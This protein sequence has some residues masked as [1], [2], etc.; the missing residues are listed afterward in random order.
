MAFPD[1]M[2]VERLVK[3]LEASGNRTC[4]RHSRRDIAAGDFL[5]SIHRY[6]RTL[7]SL[8]IGTVVL[9][10]RYEAIDTLE[11]IAAD[12]ITDLFLVEPQLFELMDHPDLES[13]D[14]SS[15]RTLTHIGASAPPALRLRARQRFGPRVVHTYGAIE[16]GLVSVLTAAE[17]DPANPEHFHSAGRVFPHVEVRLRRND[18]TI[19]VASETGS[20]EVRSPAMAQGYR[21]RP[22]LEATA[23]RDGWYRSG[24]LRSRKNRSAM[25]IHE[26]LVGVKCK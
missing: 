7:D 10:D 9:R 18:G 15:L 11:T 13:A 19:A 22:D 26:A 23:F 20:I 21:N 4:L 25:F 2:Y 12:R 8:I 6:A 14:L 17:D 1:P 24:W 16:E 3:R 5:N